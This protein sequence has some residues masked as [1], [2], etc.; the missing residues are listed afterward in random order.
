M[1]LKTRDEVISD[2]HRIWENISTQDD[3]NK[4]QIDEIVYLKNEITI[5][6]SL[7]GKKQP[8]IPKPPSYSGLGDKTITA[9]AWLFKTR[10]YIQDANLTGPAGVAQI[11][12]LLSGNAF[13][14]FQREVEQGLRSQRNAFPTTDVLF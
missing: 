4:K 12:P 8:T 2:S 5:L 11:G 1:I 3:T 7:A 9:R 6:K 13:A 14:W 10:Q